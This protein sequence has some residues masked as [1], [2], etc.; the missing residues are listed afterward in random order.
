MP[1][2]AVKKTDVIIKTFHTIDLSLYNYKKLLNPY[3]VRI[4]AISSAKV[5]ELLLCLDLSDFFHLFS[6]NSNISKPNLV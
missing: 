1:H 3:H 2:F 4:L 5:M 6:D